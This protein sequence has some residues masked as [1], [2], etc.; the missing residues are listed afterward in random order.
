[1]N[2]NKLD[3]GLNLNKLELDRNKVVEGSDQ[4]KR[5][6][7]IGPEKPHVLPVPPVPLVPPVHHVHSE[8]TGQTATKQRKEL[9]IMQNYK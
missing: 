5:K 8:N 6:F 4:N 1:M 2:Q 3:E 9:E 7:R